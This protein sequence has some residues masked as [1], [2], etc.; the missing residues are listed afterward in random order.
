MRING[1]LLGAVL[2]AAN[3]PQAARAAED[4]AKTFEEVC[5]QCHTAKKQPLDKIHLSR[6]QWGETLGRMKGY[7]ADIPKAQM[8]GL[9]DYLMHTHGPAGEAGKK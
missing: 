2:L 6:E 1:V 4:G 3:V 9:M 5:G 8:A 7:G